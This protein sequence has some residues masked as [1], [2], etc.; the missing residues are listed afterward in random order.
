MKTLDPLYVVR[1]PEVKL[2]QYKLEFIAKR[3]DEKVSQILTI[4]NDIPETTLQGQWSVAPHPS[5]P[6]HT[7]DHHAWITFSPQKFS[8]NQERIQITVDTKKLL[9][10]ATYKRELVVVNNGK[11]REILLPITIMTP[12]PQN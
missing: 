6:P 8:G 1:E 12:A 3:P 5:D 2:D 7:P 4:T 11:P 9:T 10:S